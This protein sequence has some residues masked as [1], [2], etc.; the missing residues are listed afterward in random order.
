MALMAKEKLRICIKR[1]KDELQ[2]PDVGGFQFSLI[3][4]K[5]ASGV[6]LIPLK[7]AWGRRWP[8]R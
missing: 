8:S 6:S 7:M 1:K 2:P 3:P 4:L 5:M